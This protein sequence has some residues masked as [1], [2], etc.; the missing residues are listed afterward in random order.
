MIY[1]HTYFYFLILDFSPKDIRERIP[2][3]YAARGGYEKIVKL[4]LVKSDRKNLNPPDEQDMSPMCY[5]GH[6]G[7][8]NVIHLMS[9]FL[10]QNYP[11]E[12]VMKHFARASFHST[13]SPR[14]VEYLSDLVQERSPEKHTLMH[15]ACKNGHRNLVKIL[16]KLSGTKDITKKDAHCKTPLDYAQE[17]G[18]L[19]LIR[20]VG[21]CVEGHYIPNKRFKY[22]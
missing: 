14:I 8:F 17:A 7:H 20:Y 11:S 16:L 22:E 2:L 19:S 18:H 1:F 15:F 21:F 12:I 13:S 3:H 5:A 10:L 6:K 9:E 4:L